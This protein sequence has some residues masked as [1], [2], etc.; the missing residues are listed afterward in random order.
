MGMACEQA[1][2][3]E[4]LLSSCTRLDSSEY[5]CKHICSCHESHVAKL[6]RLA[7]SES[8]YGPRM[9][10]MLDFSISLAPITY[11]EALPLPAVDPCLP[12]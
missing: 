12:L 6:S 11:F 3:L 10:S 2:L 8:V 1:C 4:G 5:D 9:H 7:D